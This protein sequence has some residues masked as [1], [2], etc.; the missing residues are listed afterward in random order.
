MSTLKSRLFA[1]EKKAIK[2]E[3][4]SS[5]QKCLMDGE[6]LN[7]ILPGQKY[8]VHYKNL[9]FY[10]RQGMH[11]KKVHGVVKFDQ[12][13]LMVYIRMNTKFRKEPK[14]DFKSNFYKLRN[15]SAFGKMKDECKGKVIEE[16]FGHGMKSKK[17]QESRGGEKEYGG[18]EGQARVLQRS[19]I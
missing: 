15:N 10:L 5:Y 7:L 2:N 4:M 8:V 16:A 18:K 19:A 9:Q 13:L 11:L 14:S 6:D 12:E 3:Q 17:Y 1:P